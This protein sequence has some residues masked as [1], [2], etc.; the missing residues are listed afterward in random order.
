[1][2]FFTEMQKAIILHEKALCLGN[3]VNLNMENFHV[4]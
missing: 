1:M 4:K 2:E 3:T